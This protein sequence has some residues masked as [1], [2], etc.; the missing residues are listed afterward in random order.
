MTASPKL[1][2]WLDAG[3]GFIYPEVCQICSG[4]RAGAAEGFVCALCWQKV[5]FITPP[6]CERCGLPYEGEINIS[7]EC[8]NCREMD[9]HFLTARSA[10]V[11][12]GLALEIIRRYKYHREMWFEPFLADL[13]IRQAAPALAREKWDMIVP[14]PLHPAKQRE[15]EF[16]QAENLALR[17]SHATSIPMNKSLLRRVEPT[18][19]QTRLSRSAR[20]ANVLQAFAL[21]G[22][23]G[24]DGERVVVLDDVFT[25]GATTSACA[26]LLKSAGAGD[27]C[28]WTVARGL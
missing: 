19:T 4:E 1:K 15:R 16:N 5:R 24:L 3:L 28:V 9:F 6:Y 12:S 18:R 14:V 7:F 27:I 8:Q 20:Q 26:R 17:L 23:T 2:A 25:T 11:A 22:E 10:V 13:L 21:R